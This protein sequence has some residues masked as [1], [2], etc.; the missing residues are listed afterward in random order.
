MSAEDQEK[1]ELRV[2]IAEICGWTILEPE[3]HPAITYDWGYPPGVV[4]ISGNREIIPDYPNSL[5]AMAGAEAMLNTTQNWI[6][7]AKEIGLIIMEERNGMGSWGLFC[8]KD[9]QGVLHGLAQ[10]I[11][12]TAIQRARAFVRTMETKKTK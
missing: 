10:F 1:A 12:A 4:G 3:V 8:Q 7:Y 5:D 2:K 9:E 11:G 6:R